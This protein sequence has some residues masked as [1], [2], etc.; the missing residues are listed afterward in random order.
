[1]E[2]LTPALERALLERSNETLVTPAADTQ[3]VCKLFDPCGAATWVLFSLEADTDGR[4]RSWR[5]WGIADLGMD[6]VEY[7]SIDLDEL[8]AHRGRLGLGIERDLHFDPTAY[9]FAELLA[10]E[11]LAGV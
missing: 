7:G 5:A 8:R 9:T 11:R 3:P 2:L 4:A 10:R 6:C 1:M